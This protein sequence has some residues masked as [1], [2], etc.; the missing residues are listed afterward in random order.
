METIIEMKD[1][2]L[3]RQGKFLLK[4][5]NWTVKR[6]EVWAI[7]GLNGAG[8]STL[9]RL[10]MADTWKTSGSL[11]VLGQTFGQGDIPSLRQKIGVVSSFLAERFPSQLL[12]E[13]IVLTGRY[14][15]SI[16]YKSYDQ[17]ELKEAK[18]L[19]TALGSQDLIG[20]KYLSLSQGERQ[21]LLIARSL[22]D[23]PEILIF[24]EATSGLDLFAREKLLG[25]IEKISQLDDAPSIIYVTH[26]AQEIS[27]TMSHLL[28]L[29]DGE[30]VAQGEKSQI[31]KKEILSQFYGQG[32]DIIPLGQER[33][34]VKAEVPP[35]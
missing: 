22:M 35:C 10:I 4:N 21:S 17:A 9:L 8:K 33:Y 15:S 34:F 19:L 20:R 28:L 29:R 2:S 30:I 18:S 5:L 27:Q 1:L 12:S 23:Q 32:V 16:L 25:Q 13:Q 24:D 11:E 6:G 31:F 26:H 14:K 3:M 7:L